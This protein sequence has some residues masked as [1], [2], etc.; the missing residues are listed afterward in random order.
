MFSIFR[1]TP[2]ILP[3]VS[4]TGVGEVKAK[5]DI[6]YLPI[7]VISRGKSTDEA[8]RENAALTAN[9]IDTLQG[10]GIKHEDL[11]TSGPQVDAEYKEDNGDSEETKEPELIGY[12][13]LNTVLAT[14]RDIK[15]VGNIID[16][17]AGAGNYPIGRVSYDLDDESRRHLLEA[18]LRN[19]VDDASFKAEI[20]AGEEGKEISDLKSMAIND[21]R[22][23][24]GGNPKA[25]RAQTAMLS[26]GP[27]TEVN[28]GD[29]TISTSVQVEYFV[30]DIKEE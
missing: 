20:A 12:R 26:S 15:K 22:S 7:N 29:I 4:V 2:K 6:A 17:V 23:F 9:L 1:T 24:G 8:I 30:D 27:Q 19:A 5:P 3:I 21:H 11:E 25:L 28:P 13:A 16:V 10:N 14:I 18:A